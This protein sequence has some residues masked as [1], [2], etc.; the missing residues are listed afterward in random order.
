MRLATDGEVRWLDQAQEVFDLWDAT[1]LNLRLM[2]KTLMT[3]EM[4]DTYK[5]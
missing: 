1:P 4:V 3:K 5:L 2:A